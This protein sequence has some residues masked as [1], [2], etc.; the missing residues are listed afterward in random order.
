MSR[1]DTIIEVAK[2][3]PYHDERGRFTSGGNASFV[4]IRTKDPKKQHMAD[5]AA[6]REKQRSKIASGGGLSGMS[7][8]KIAQHPLL[9]DVTDASKPKVL[10]AFRDAEA[11]YEAD[12]EAKRRL[13]KMKPG[14][15]SIHWQSVLSAAVSEHGQSKSNPGKSI[16]EVRRKEAED[17]LEESGGYLPF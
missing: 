8:E 3:N 1:Y 12:A 10:R 2:F 5:R 14:K 11:S 15:R 13:D 16:K 6:E 4:T 7:D 17:F 9:N